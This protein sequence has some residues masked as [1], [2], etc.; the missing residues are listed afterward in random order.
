MNQ[1]EIT[2]KLWVYIKK[3][4]LKTVGG[5]ESDNQ[6]GKQVN[7]QGKPCIKKSPDHY[8]N[9]SKRQ[10]INAEHIV[11]NGKTWKGGDQ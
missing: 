3:N 11:S 8:R 7:E 1:T 2:K 9:N 4:K 6:Y 10:H 5:P